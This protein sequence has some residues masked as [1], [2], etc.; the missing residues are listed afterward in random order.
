MVGQ[1]P[2]GLGV[3]DISQGGVIMIHYILTAGGLY[4]AILLIILKGLFDRI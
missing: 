1:V 3:H 4:L 2:F